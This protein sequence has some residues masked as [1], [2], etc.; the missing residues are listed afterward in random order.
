M[1]EMRRRLYP[2]EQ[3]HQFDEYGFA[4]SRS[5]GEIPIA[6]ASLC[7]CTCNAIAHMHYTCTVP[8]GNSFFSLC[9]MIRH[10]ASQE[11]LP[12]A[13][14]K[15]AARLQAAAFDTF[16]APSIVLLPAWHGLDR[17]VPP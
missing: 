5:L 17:P 6:R 16:V 2:W 10:R 15:F 9:S 14:R 4:D 7:M 12:R 1:E 3:N 13:A 11:V 8:G